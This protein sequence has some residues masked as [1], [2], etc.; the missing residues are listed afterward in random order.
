MNYRRK[1]GVLEPDEGGFFEAM[2]LLFGVG[3]WGCGSF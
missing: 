1:G 2:W 3:V